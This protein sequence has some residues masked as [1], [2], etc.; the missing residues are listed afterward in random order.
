MNY[1]CCNWMHLKMYALN[2]FQIIDGQQNITEIDALD[3]R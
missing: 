3:E 2:Y 1:L